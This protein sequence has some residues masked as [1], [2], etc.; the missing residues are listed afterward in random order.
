TQREDEANRREAELNEREKSLAAHDG[1]IAAS[2][3]DIEARIRDLAVKEKRVGSLEDEL[4]YRRQAWAQGVPP[5]LG[6]F[7]IA[8]APAGEPPRRGARSSEGRRGRSSSPPPVVPFEEP[9]P[10]EAAAP[11]EPAA[12][13]EAETLQAP[14]LQ[15]FADRAPT[16]TPRLD[17][18]LL[19]GIPPK[20][21]LM[22]IGDAFVGK[23]TAIYAFLAEGLKLGEPALVITANRG[24]DELAQKIGVV[25]PQLQEYEQLGMVRWIDASAAEAPDTAAPETSGARLRTNGPHDHPGILSALVQAANAFQEGSDRPVRVAFFGLSATLAHGDERQRLQFL[26]NFVGG[27]KNRHAIALYAL[28][29]GTVPESQLETVLSRMDGAI[30]FKREG[31]KTFLSVRGVGEV[32][33]R[34]WIEYRATNR[35]LVIGSFSLERIR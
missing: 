19:G 35:A 34:D 7:S 32:Q 6:N 23:E 4:R 16:G 3:S 11:A 1:E 26:Q 27:L 24:P 14:A 17:D 18:L 2:R 12:P 21:H 25:A 15:R 29:T 31:G 22:L 20:G 10:D 30:Y 28:E 5:T 9:A 8:F 13:A 33:T